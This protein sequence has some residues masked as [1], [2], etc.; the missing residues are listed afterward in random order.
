MIIQRPIKRVCTPVLN[1]TRLFAQNQVMNI[2]KNSLRKASSRI[3]NF[4]LG[5]SWKKKMDFVFYNSVIIDAI[6]AQR[7]NYWISLLFFFGTRK[8]KFVSI[9][10]MENEKIR[11]VIVKNLFTRIIQFRD[12]EWKSFYFHFLS[13]LLSGCL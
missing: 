10:Q 5:V 1:F 11:T 12:F 6:T 9:I 4:D 8:N 7:S 2:Q 3:W 13:E